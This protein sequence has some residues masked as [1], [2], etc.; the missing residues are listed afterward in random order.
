MRRIQQLQPQ[1]QQLNFTKEK[2]SHPLITIFKWKVV[3][4][5]HRVFKTIKYKIKKK[6]DHI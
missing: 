6:V 2:R 5:S 1:I 4:N 3:R